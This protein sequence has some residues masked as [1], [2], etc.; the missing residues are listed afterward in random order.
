M[1]QVNLTSGSHFDCSDGISILESA[2]KAQITLPYSCKTGRCSSCK[3]KVLSGQSRPLVDELGLTSEE[4][5]DG[6]I[7]SCARTATSDLLIEVEDISGFVIPTIKTLP[8]RINSLQKLAP[9]VLR[10]I[11]RVPPNSILNYL[12]GQYVNVIGA[13]GIRRSYSIANAPSADGQLE[14]HIRAVAGGAMS[15]YWFNEAKADDLVRINGP[16]GSF[17][18]RETA[19]LD[20]VFLATGT[21]IAPVKAMIET[22]PQLTAN[23][24]PRSVTVVWGGRVQN[25]MYLDVASM[26]GNHVFIPV[27]S[28]ASSSWS[29]ARGYVQQALL[30]VQPDLSK[31]A[32]YACGSD[33]MIHSARLEL[34]G[35]GLPSNRFYSDAFVSSAAS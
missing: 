10:V 4:K 7:L 24:L 31:A 22:L 18:L 13:G 32:V 28:R 29:G 21:G 1:A 9:D 25:D 3:C 2:A 16:L 19:G 12:P 34:F 15:D 26:S 20:L 6:W 11:L 23:K 17:F 33:A 8:A 14:L 35:A 27:L 5:E 30:E